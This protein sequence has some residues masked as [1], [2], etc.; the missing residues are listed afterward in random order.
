MKKDEEPIKGYDFKLKKEEI[1]KIFNTPDYQEYKEKKKKTQK[2]KENIYKF[3]S[4]GNSTNTVRNLIILNVFFFILSYIIPSMFTYFAS[5]NIMSPNFGIWQPFT[6]MFLHGGFIH[7]A[8]NMFVLWSF[9]NQTEEVL[10]LKKFLTLYILSG[11]ISGIFCMFFGAGPAVG[12]SGALCGLMAAYVFI[13]PESTVLLFFI[14]PMKIKNCVYGFAVF[15]LVFGILSL[16][17][18][19]LGFGIAHFGHLG[20]LVGGYL[21]TYYWKRNN[22]IQTF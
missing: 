2:R 5:Y 8:L 3:T 21:L 12:A 16:I 7:L 11:I 4:I 15:S 17:D 18:S 20:G 22:L 1:K 9:G 13:A 19:S 14:I 6:S 10:G